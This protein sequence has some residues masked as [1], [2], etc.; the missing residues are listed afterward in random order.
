MPQLDILTFFGQI[1]TLFFCICFIFMF[2][3]GFILPEVYKNKKASIFVLK[4][5]NKANLENI[6]M[7]LKNI[8]LI[9]TSSIEQEITSTQIFYNEVAIACFDD[10]S[11]ELVEDSQ[12]IILE[13]FFENYT[14]C[15][16]KNEKFVNAS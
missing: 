16:V 14:V 7:I 1:I 8:N 15:Q 12:D 6:E 10:Q 11:S 3:V 4:Q 13:N 5:T 9:Y 2:N